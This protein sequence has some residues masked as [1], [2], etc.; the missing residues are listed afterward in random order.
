[1]IALGTANFIDP[2]AVDKV[3]KGLSSFCLEKQ[4]NL[5]DIVGKVNK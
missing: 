4:L 2:L 5:K 1:M 3:Y